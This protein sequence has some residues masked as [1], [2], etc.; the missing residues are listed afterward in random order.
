MFTAEWKKREEPKDKPVVYRCAQCK[1][2]AN[3]T[4]GLIVRDCGHDTAGVTADLSAT[5]KGIGSLEG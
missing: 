1:A 4:D 3:V 2:P 5:M